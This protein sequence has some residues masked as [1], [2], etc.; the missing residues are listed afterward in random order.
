MN[1]LSKAA[2]VLH[3]GSIYCMSGATLAFILDAL[4]MYDIRHCQTF[5]RPTQFRDAYLMSHNLGGEFPSET[6]KAKD[7]GWSHC[8]RVVFWHCNDTCFTITPF[9]FS[10]GGVDLSAPAGEKWASRTL[11]PPPRG[12]I[13]ER[14]AIGG[15]CRRRRK[16][17]K[18]EL[19]C[20][21]NT[22]KGRELYIYKCVHVC[23]RARTF[24]GV[25]RMMQKGKREKECLFLI[26]AE[27]AAQAQRCIIT[28]L[29]ERHNHRPSL[30]NTRY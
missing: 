18:V 30:I 9:P 17:R 15:D 8:A 3:P 20:F 10:F 28:Y 23:V 4:P 25:D 21:Q 5:S 26:A 1:T 12:H 13:N 19:D 16:K 2:Y 7:G 27:A 14:V 29:T 6:S 24:G 22:G 11:P